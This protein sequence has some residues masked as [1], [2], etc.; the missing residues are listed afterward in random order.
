MRAKDSVRL[1]VIRGVMSAVTNELVAKG[2]GPGGE[3]T[4]E[5]LVAVIR[6][7]AKQ[8]KDSI[9]QFT[10]GSRADL[11]ESEQA[12]LNVLESMLPALMPQEEVHTLAV[13]KMTELGI[14]DAS[15]ANQLMAALMKDLKGKA[16][17]T[18]VK[19]VVDSLFA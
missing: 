16:D 14:N 2:R 4:E 9:E 13:A 1:G 5:E 7:A 6:K 19:A 12:E 3:L 18:V 10:A 11:A 15:Q 17:G 8:R